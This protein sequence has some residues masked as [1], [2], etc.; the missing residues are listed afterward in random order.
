MRI[1]SPWQPRHF[2]LIS[3][4]IGIKAENMSTFDQEPVQGSPVGGLLKRGEVL[5]DEG[6]LNEAENIFLSVLERDPGSVD[7]CNNLGVIAFSRGHKAE[8]ID[9]MTRA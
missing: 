8:T 3:Q 6:R 9:Y 5:F 4:R 7:A 1:R 2:S